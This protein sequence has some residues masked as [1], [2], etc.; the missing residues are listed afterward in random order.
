M[1][2]NT[3]PEDWYPYEKRKSLDADIYCGKRMAKT[4]GEDS[5]P[6][7]KEGGPEQILPPQP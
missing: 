4:Q 7:G 3:H 2:P 6:E 1:G 5:L